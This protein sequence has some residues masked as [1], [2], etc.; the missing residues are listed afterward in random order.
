MKKFLSL[1]D[2][3]SEIDPSR[4]VAKRLK[5]MRKE[6]TEAEKVLADHALTRRR[7]YVL[8]VAALKCEGTAYVGKTINLGPRVGHALVL[9]T[10]YG[11][12][13]VKYLGNGTSPEYGKDVERDLT[14]DAIAKGWSTA[15][16]VGR[17]KVL[18]KTRQAA[19]N[20]RQT[21]KERI[22]KVDNCGGVERVWTA[23]ND[24]LLFDSLRAGYVGRPARCLLLLLRACCW[25]CCYQ[26]ATTTTS[27]LP[28]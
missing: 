14:S 26:L 9:S 18:Q 16:E 21:N 20:L 8:Q 13:R 6:M 17:R 12:G 7:D 19:K 27:T 22:S 4:D 24:V 3:I 28:Y 25:S 10:T 11:A 23:V 2:G 1:L 5:S 15:I